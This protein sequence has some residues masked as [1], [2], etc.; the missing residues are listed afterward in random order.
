MIHY[1]HFHVFFNKFIFIIYYIL[2]IFSLLNV[3]SL[4]VLVLNVM[5]SKKKVQYYYNSHTCFK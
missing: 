2:K 5:L 1:F 4:I 3:R